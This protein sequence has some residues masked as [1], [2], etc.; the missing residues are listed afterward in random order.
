[1]LATFF[2]EFFLAGHTLLK[3]KLGTVTKL[4]VATFLAL[5]TFQLAEYMLCGGLG[6]TG[7]EWA[8]LGYGAITLL[9]AIGIHLIVTL[10]GK[11][12][13]GL[14][15][16]AYLT[17]AAFLAFFLFG[18]GAVS[19]EAC[20][21]N[22]AVFNTHAFGAWPFAIYYYGWLIVG[23]VLTVL[24]SRGQKKQKRRALYGMTGGYIAFIA[25]T[26]F[27]NL[28][29]PSTVSGIPSI[30]CGFAVLFALALAF[31]VLPNSATKRPSK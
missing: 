13:R 20:Y 3:Y 15:A 9:P 29:D 12:M 18:G 24:W 25:P 17:C 26:T 10:A 19:A 23:L 4:A 22:Y 31:V 30:M 27:F 6:W 21:A 28:I 7:F 8:R 11:K 1:M 16:F 5:G 14:V 2:I